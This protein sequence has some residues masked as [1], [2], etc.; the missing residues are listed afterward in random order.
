[1]VKRSDFTAALFHNSQIVH[2][3]FMCCL[4]EEPS[5]LS[6]A[7]VSHSRLDVRDLGVTTPSYLIDNFCGLFPFLLPPLQ[8]LILHVFPS[9]PLLD[10]G[11]LF[12][13]SSEIL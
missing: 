12:P 4:V 6:L 10:Y 11:N 5:L 9:V 3:L 2:L 7:L 13:F 1:M 8:Y